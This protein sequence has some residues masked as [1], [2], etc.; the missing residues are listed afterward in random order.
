[1]G[2]WVGG[3]V[4]GERYLDQN[5][6]GGGF[7]HVIDTEGGDRGPIER[8]HFDP[9]LALDPDGA[10][11]E[12][13]GEVGGWVGGWVCGWAGRGRG[14]GW[15]EVLWVRNGWV[16]G[17]EGGRSELPFRPRSCLAPGRCSR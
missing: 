7:A 11:N 9:C 14:G 5:V 4:G 13:L 8:F 16:G 3:W 2:G 6:V 1:M 10:V 15:N 17:E 12:D